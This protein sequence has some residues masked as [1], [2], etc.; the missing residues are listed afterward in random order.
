LIADFD[1]TTPIDGIRRDALG[2]G[3]C[4][5]H[6]FVVRHDLVH[7]PEL[8][9][10]FC[11][12]APPG[13]NE[14]LGFLH[15]DQPRQP[16]ARAAAGKEAVRRF[17]QRKN[18]AL[19]SDADVA[20]KHKLEAARHAVAVD[21]GEHRLADVGDHARPS[22]HYV[23]PVVHHRCRGAS[24]ALFEVRAAAECFVSRAGDHDHAHVVVEIELRQE[25]RQFIAQLRI[26]RV[27]RLGAVQ[28]ND[29]NAV[30]DV[31]QM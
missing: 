20:L 21:R 13:K 5:F 7:E 24:G 10:L 27:H 11:I 15:A 31:E 30:G 3:H 8:R 28:G 17:G 6:D 19:G 4:F 25:C 16:L 14:L 9:R 1:W 23:K 18:G 12:P 29:G 22:R 26:E 2:H